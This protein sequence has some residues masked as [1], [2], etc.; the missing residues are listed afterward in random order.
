[1]VGDPAAREDVLLKVFLM[2]AAAMI[3]IGVG[4]GIPLLIQ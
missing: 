3:G 1:L 4:L 2:I